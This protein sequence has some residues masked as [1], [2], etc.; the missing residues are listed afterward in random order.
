MRPATPL[1]HYGDDAIRWAARRRPGIPR[2]LGA[3]GG[4]DDPLSEDLSPAAQLVAS[5][6]LLIDTGARRA[7]PAPDTAIATWR[8]WWAKPRSAPAAPTPFSVSAT[9]AL[10]AAAARSG[11]SWQS[12]APSS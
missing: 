8:E 4:E 7:T 9:G 5:S 1:Y 2:N 11:P 6:A 3:A 12:A 10:P